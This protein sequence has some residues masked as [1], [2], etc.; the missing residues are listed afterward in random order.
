MA[1]GLERFDQAHGLAALRAA[2]SPVL[3]CWVGL[4]RGCLFS[5]VA[6]PE[7]PPDLIKQMALAVAEEAV[8]PDLDKAFGQDMLQETPDE[9]S[10]IDGAVPGCSGARVLVAKGDLVVFHF[11][12]AIVTDRCREPDTSKQLLRCR[13]VGSEPPNL[14]STSQRGPGQIEVP[15]SIHR[16]TWPGTGSRGA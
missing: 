12:D 1:F 3:G 5:S 11:Q 9:L 6:V 15:S 13:R 4:L 7:Q 10:S 16:G 2:Q 8:I 14:S